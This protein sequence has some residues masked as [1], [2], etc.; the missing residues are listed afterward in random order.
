MSS[1]GPNRDWKTAD[2]NAGGQL[3][4]L[5][6]EQADLLKSISRHLNELEGYLTQNKTMT[7]EGAYRCFFETYD[8]LEDNR[9]Q[10]RLLLNQSTLKA[11]TMT[12]SVC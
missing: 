11:F 3:K 12:P 4:T 8:N 7:A 9:Q 1:K 10:Q 6:K 2:W 5:E